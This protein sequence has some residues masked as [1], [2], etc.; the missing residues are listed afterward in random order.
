MRTAWIIPLTI[1]DTSSVFLPLYR[2]SNLALVREEFVIRAL[3]GAA[4]CPQDLHAKR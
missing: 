1:L 3:S 4:M 2:P